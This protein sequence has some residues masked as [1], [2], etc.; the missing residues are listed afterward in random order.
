MAYLNKH[1]LEILIRLNQVSFLLHKK[2]N[3]ILYNFQNELMLIRNA[4]NEQK[5]LTKD[6]AKKRYIEFLK[7]MNPEFK[8][9]TE[10]EIKQTKVK[11]I[12]VQTNL[13][14][15]FFLVWNL[16]QQTYYVR[17]RIT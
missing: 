5:G 9:D 8:I 13:S 12:S 11:N 1:K 15:N 3:G 4:W 14:F 16:S 6:K 17:R 2:L 10:E 7:K